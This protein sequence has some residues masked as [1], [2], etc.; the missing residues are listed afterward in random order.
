MKE[1]IAELEERHRRNN[2]GFMGIKGKSRV[3]SET[4]EESKRILEVFLQEKL[5]L[6]TDEITIESSHL[7]R[8]KKGDKKMDHNSKI[9]ELQ[10]AS[11]SVK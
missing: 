3:K 7:I 4:W 10:A 11:E 8:K 5:G 2:L 9:F 1:Q 6:G